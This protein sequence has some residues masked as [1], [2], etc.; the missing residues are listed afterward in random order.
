VD[1]CTDLEGRAR[2]TL[3]PLGVT[4]VGNRRRR[5]LSGARNTGCEV[6]RGDVVAFLDDDAE[7]EAGWLA[8][9]AEQY[10]DEGVLGV[11]GQVVPRW[12]AGEP[13]WFPREFG[14]VVG[15]SY[16]G[17]PTTA[18]A[19]RNPIGANMSFRRDVIRGAGGFAETLG[20]VGAVPT[21][22]EETELAIRAARI[23]PQGRVVHE[24][25]AVVHHHVPRAR[26]QWRYFRRRCWSEG[27]SKAWVSRLADPRSALASE[28]TYA[29]RTLPAGVRR[30]LVSA[31]RETEAGAAA[32]AAVIV[33]GL[34]VTTAGYLSARLTRNPSE[35]REE[36]AMTPEE[37]DTAAGWLHFDLH[38]RLGVRVQESSPAA[39]Q[40]RTMLACFATRRTVPD[41]IVVSEQCEEVGPTSDLENE[42]RYTDHSVEMLQ[43]N[44]Q[45]VR[46]GSSYR[47]HGSGEL[48]TALVPVLDRAMVERGAAMIHA[49]TVG[50]RGY[51]VAL[52]AAGG[53]GKTST[54]AKLM[55]RPDYSFMGD[56]WAFLSEDKQLLGYEKPMFIK[57]HHRPIYPHL[58]QGVRKPMVPVALTRPVGR[59][60][61]AVH[62]LII[63]YPRWA[64]LARRWSPEHRMVAADRALPGVPVTTSAPLLVSVYVERFGGDDVQLSEVSTEWMVD[65]MLGNFHV[66]MAG[67]SQRLVTALA[68][69]S[70]LSWRSLV[71]DKADLLTK[72]LSGTPCYLLQVPRDHAPD[73]ASDE[74]VEVLD[75]LLP[76]LLGERAG[77]A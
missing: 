76:S 13:R 19:V 11:G 59:L 32:Q 70:M 30:N 31:V 43:E 35:P 21:G 28:R 6:A 67:F 10:R 41:D 39:A 66:E 58:F 3:A 40:L 12:E 25:A 69:A 49:A 75:D 20:R 72:A 61:T 29:L 54:V 38:G 36:A 65:R 27:R 52:P 7:A 57:P 63:R 44:V 68:A 60:T 53:T 50:Y 5:G 15:C 48:L 22:C 74:V 14:W 37:P 2:E 33:A 9:H 18:A 34:A 46:D 4:V 64:D 16:V 77:V 55:R 73:D 71:D 17:L 47:V 26:G 23:L 51:G 24:P 56:D 62:P 42:M 45:L 1:H 8:A